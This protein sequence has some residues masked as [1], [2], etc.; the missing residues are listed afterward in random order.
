MWD[1]KSLAGGEQADLLAPSRFLVGLCG[2]RRPCRWPTSGTH[3]PTDCSLPSLPTQSLNDD[4][5]ACAGIASRLFDVLSQKV[6]PT[7]RRTGYCRTGRFFGP[8]LQDSSRSRAST[9][10]H[11]IIYRGVVRMIRH[12]FVAM[13]SAIAVLLAIPLAASADLPIRK[14]DAFNP[15]DRTVDVFKAMDD[16]EI[17]V[18]FI[19]KDEKEAM[20]LIENKTD[21]PL[22]VKLPE[23]F[24]GVPVL[25]Q[26]GGIGGGGLGGGLAAVAA[27]R[28]RRN[29]R[30]NG[31]RF[32]WRACG[33]GV[34]NVEPGL[35][36]K[37]KVTSVCLEHGKPDPTPHMKYTIKPIEEVDRSRSHRTVQDARPRR[38]RS[39]LG[40]SRRVASA[41]RPDVG[42]TR[43][44][45]KKCISR[46]ATSRCIS[47]A[48]LAPRDQGHASRRRTGEE[49]NGR[50]PRR[51][52]AG[53]AS[54]S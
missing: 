40:A 46:T 3:G 6:L 36:G 9:C 4:V 26:I 15:A 17:E 18:K 44:R 53:A 25:A 42:G 21:K 12:R 30:R 48:Q 38:N 52:I 39:S 10:G 7:A 31:R 45:K 37:A 33:G 50:Q 43:A 8:P 24:A 29:G 54:D 51:N 19:P 16:G 49:P 34:L 28:R 41:R 11:C 2:L 5:A 32:G 22:N 23:A 35:V 47:T 14:P 1:C 20:L 27:R 13:L